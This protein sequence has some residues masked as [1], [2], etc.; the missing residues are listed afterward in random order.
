MDNKNTKDKE[1]KKKE[2]DYM[3]RIDASSYNVENRPFNIEDVNNKNI[4]S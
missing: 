1:E 4:A 2:F 3:S